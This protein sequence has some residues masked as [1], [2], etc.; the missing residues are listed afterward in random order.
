MIVTEASDKYKVSMF[1]AQSESL[2]LSLDSCYIQRSTK[3]G[4]S[5][6]LFLNSFPC[7][8]SISVCMPCLCFF[9]F[10]FNGGYNTVWHS[11][12]SFGVSSSC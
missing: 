4:F 5:S 7:E 6:V 9:N 1:C 10:R 2:S 12:K 3:F 8:R 11:E